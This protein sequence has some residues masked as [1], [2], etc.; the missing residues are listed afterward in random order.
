M[1]GPK[2]FLDPQQLAA[3]VAEVGAIAAAEDVRI[4]LIGGFAMVHYG[5]DRLTGDVDF[6]ATAVP[7][8]LPGGPPLSFGGI[9]T[10]SPSGVPVDL[11]V[12]DDDYRSLYEEAI[13]RAV[14]VPELPVALVSAAH[15]AAMKMVAARDRDTLDLEFLIRTGALDLPATRAVIRAHL[16]AYAADEFDRLVDEVEWKRHRDER[17]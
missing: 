8:G 4:I 15:L 17:K 6:A 11:V 2:R 12:R 1:S 14:L 5:S 3:A 7:G 16:G 9:H 10:T 13:E